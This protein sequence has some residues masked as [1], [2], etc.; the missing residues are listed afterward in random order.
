MTRMY[1]EIR[2]TISGQENAVLLYTRKAN[3]MMDG[4]LKSK[5]N[6]ITK[7]LLF[8]DIFVVNTFKIQDGCMQVLVKT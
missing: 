1:T 6:F 4:L 8:L 3:L 2:W 7:A 5:Y